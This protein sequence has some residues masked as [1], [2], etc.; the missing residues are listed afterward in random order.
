MSRKIVVFVYIFSLLCVNTTSYA[1]VLIGK[2]SL[3]GSLG[4][5]TQ[6]CASPSFN[7]FDVGFNF[8]LISALDPTNQFIVELSDASGSFSDAITLHTSNAGEITTEGVNVEFNFSLPTTV[9]GEGY[10]VRIR[11][12]S[13]S[14]VSTSS[15]AFAAYYKLHDSS[16]TINNLNDTGGYCTGGSY[17]LSIDNPGSGLEGSPL[18]Y[19]SLTYR[20]FRA[21]SETTS[22]FV[23]DG[24]TLSVNTP[25]IYFVETNYGSCTS[26]SASNRVTVSEVTSTS[27]SSISSSLGETFCATEGLTTLTTINAFAYQW[28]KDGETIIDATEQ[29]FQTNETGEYSVNIDLGTCFTSAS[30]N[31]DTTGFTSSIDVDLENDNDLSQDE[32]FFATITTT[33]NTP[34][35]EWYLNENLITGEINNDLEITETGNYEVII[36]QTV[37]CNAKESFNFTVTTAFPDVEEIPNLISPNGDGE[38]DTW[39]LPLNY[40]GGTNT[41]VVIMSSRGEIIFKT[42]NYQNNWPQDELSF[43]AIN[44]LYYYIITPSNGKTRKGTI[45]VV[46]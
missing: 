30:I 6:A 38:N 9:S 20:W 37:G 44:P 36:T 5:V 1:Q 8:S 35:F 18:Q 33:A 14:S 43:T 22:V 31:L 21:T 25:G 39:V 12:T 16:F 19:D 27:T 13:P 28:F 11:S 46:K 10:R 17:I 45:T 32:T 2:P 26:E 7:S 41:N 40:V 15:D 23:A 34:E 4:V 24:E 29:E 3:G 42:N